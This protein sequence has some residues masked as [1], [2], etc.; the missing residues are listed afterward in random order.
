MTGCPVMVT[1]NIDIDRESARKIGT[2]TGIE[3]YWPMLGK[4]HKRNDTKSR[5]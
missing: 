3:S 2:V 1:M 5:P 4:S